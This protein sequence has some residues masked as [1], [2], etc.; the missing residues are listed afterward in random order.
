M[1]ALRITSLTATLIAAL[2]LTACSKNDSTAE[3]A[4]PA[5]S[6]AAASTPSA[7]SVEASSPSPAAPAAT[8]SSAEVS[9]ERDLA[10][11]ANAL[12]GATEASAAA[13]GAPAAAVAPAV[14]APAA[15]APVVATAAPVAAPAKPTAADVEAARKQAQIEWAL[16]QDEI[17]NDPNGQWATGAKASSTFNDAKG[18]T[19]YSANQAT[20]EPNVQV[21]STTPQAWSSKTP[22]SGIE[23]L[24]LTFTKAVRASAVRVRE[25][26]GSGALIKIEVF[27][28]KGAAHTVWSGTDSTKELNYLIA[29]FPKTAFTTNRVKLT[30]ATNVVSGWNQIDAVQLVGSKQ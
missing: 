28:D 8:P 20:G 2:L 4:A 16:K 14:S 24:E 25:S 3:A 13:P 18:N 22:D 30:L 12:A 11:A 27:D 6:A 7:K 21:Y 5:A 9:P 29:E 17:K 15:P 26:S 1:T 23:W 10:T 19:S